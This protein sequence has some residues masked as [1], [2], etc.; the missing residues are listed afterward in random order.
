MNYFLLLNLGFLFLCTALKKPNFCKDC[1]YFIS[2]DSLFF[3]PKPEFGKCKLF[4]RVIEND[5][6]LVTG[7]NNEINTEYKYCSIVRN[8]N[9]MCGIEGKLFEIKKKQNFFNKN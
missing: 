8:S 3:P 1:K 5:N 2:S 7:E 4:P 9:N 6:Y